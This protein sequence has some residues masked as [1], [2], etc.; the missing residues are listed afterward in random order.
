MKKILL[1]AFIA[2]GATA[3]AQN[4]L[5]PQATKFSANFGVDEMSIVDAN[6][7]WINAYD[8]SGAGTYPKQISRTTNGGATWTAVT[9]PSSQIPSNCLISDLHGIDGQTA[10][11]IAAVATA[12]VSNNGIWK[13][14]NGGTTWT[15]QTSGFGGSS[16]SFAN[17]IHFWDA[18]NGWAAGDPVNGKFE[19]Y[20]TSNG[21]TTWTAVASAPTPIA[22]QGTEFSYVGVK[23]V[24][25]DNIW[26]GTDLG[27]ILHSSD[28][29][30][31]WNAYFT[32]ALDFGGVTT[33]GS[34]AK[35]AF[36][37]GTKGVLLTVDNTSDA[38]LYETSDSG[39]SWD[40][41]EPTGPWYFGDIT[42]VPGTPNTYV[43][44]GINYNDDSWMG[45]SYSNDGGHTWIGIDGGE[46][47]GAV[48]FLNATTGWVGQFSD[49]P[50]GTK[51]I[52]KF[53]GSV[54][55]ASDVAVKSNLKVFPNPAVDVVTVTSNKD[56]KKV[57]V[58]DLSGKKVSSTEGNKINVS[59]LSKGNYILQVY[60]GNGGVE[61][62]KLIKK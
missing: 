44:T 26:I 57:T 17:Q 13:T 38:A 29:G 4:S 10:Y 20:K 21:G 46:Q 53:N 37:S 16:D 41:I 25:G 47:R 33:S 39:A 54:L 61:N 31:T 42:Y 2:M 28:R 49:G 14:T 22:G 48:K 36:S 55:A 35:M 1:S 24:V 3:F 51:G 23:D 15:K 59:A 11:L 6:T 40:P 58:Y 62:T 43:S 9:I 30:T 19:M 52:L 18:N 32:P 50:A 34:S 45:T 12:P 27:R 8:G 7:V 5:V 56:V 60:Y